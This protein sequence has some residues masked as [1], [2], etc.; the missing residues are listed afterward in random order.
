MSKVKFDINSFVEAIKNDTIS[1]ES[2]CEYFKLIKNSKIKISDYKILLRAVEQYVTDVNFLKA[3]KYTS[4]EK[5][6]I[7]KIPYTN[8]FIVL[9]RTKKDLYNVFAIENKYIYCG[10]V[11]YDCTDL[12]TQILLRPSDAHSFIELFL[13][14]AYSKK[15]TA[16]VNIYPTVITLLK[17]IFTTWK[18][19]SN[20]ANNKMKRRQRAKKI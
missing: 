13:I 2:L 7:Y 11:I 9:V 15:L 18:V 12:Y 5:N 16:Y 8:G 17:S 20:F 19:P 10:D 14:S 4:I 1:A 3:I 6:I